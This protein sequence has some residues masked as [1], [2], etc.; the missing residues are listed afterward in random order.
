VV[1]LGTGFAACW[2]DRPA[3]L[4]QRERSV[5]PRPPSD[6]WRVVPMLAYGRDVAGNPRGLPV[7][8]SFP[9]LQTLSLYPPA[10]SPEGR[11][12]GFGTGADSM[13]KKAQTSK[14]E[15][16]R[17]AQ[18]DK[19]R[20]H[21][22]R[23]G[24]PVWANMY[25]QDARPGYKGAHSMAAPDVDARL[26]AEFHLSGLITL[27]HLLGDEEQSSKAIFRMLDHWELSALFGV[28]ERQ[29]RD[30]LVAIDEL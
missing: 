15:A 24:R 6:Q 29:A 21:S 18:N 8:V 1:A 20:G 26:R 4:A 17:S 2:N 7:M 23:A 12:S 10:P 5:R 27:L 3:T 16:A 28:M 13:K 30:A 22:A 25:E 11:G 19:P 14:K 9:G